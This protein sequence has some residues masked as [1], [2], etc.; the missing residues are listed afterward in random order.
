[1]AAAKETSVV[2]PA[3]VE[4]EE[5]GGGRGGAVRGDVGGDVGSAGIGF[6]D[7]TAAGSR[8]GKGTNVRVRPRRRVVAILECFVPQQSG[9]VGNRQFLY[10]WG[11]GLR[12]LRDLLHHYHIA[13]PSAA[14]AAAAGA[15]WI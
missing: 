2:A 10:G 3:V 13:R 4:M 8:A 7:A 14:A 9:R 6:R 11:W 12:I 5:G 15:T 1:M